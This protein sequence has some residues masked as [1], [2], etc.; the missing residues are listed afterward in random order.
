MVRVL[1]H[2]GSILDRPDEQGSTA[3]HR[4]ARAGRLNV[5]KFLI[6]SG[7]KVDP[8]DKEGRLGKERERF[9][10]TDLICEFVL[11]HLPGSPATQAIPTCWLC[12][13]RPARTTM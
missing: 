2:Y 6:R 4:A 5:V 9:G 11:G 12:W 10:K 7:A 1:L 8:E 13:F 3:M